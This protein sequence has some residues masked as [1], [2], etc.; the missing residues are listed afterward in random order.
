MKGFGSSPNKSSVPPRWKMALLTWI[1][2]WPISI[3]VSQ[4][5]EPTL[6]RTAPH[7]LAAGLASD[8]KYLRI[9]DLCQE[10]AF[11]TQRGPR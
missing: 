10:L 7:V 1:V 2:V 9:C 4:I 6:L 8:H 11:G 5:L 3:F